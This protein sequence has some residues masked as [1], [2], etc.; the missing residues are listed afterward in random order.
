MALDDM[1]VLLGE[2]EA[3]GILHMAAVDDIGERGDALA[4]IVLQPHRAHHL[5]IDRGDLLARPQIRD[6]LGAVLFSDTEGDAAAG[7]AAV[8]PE[9]QARLLRRAAMDE[10]IDAER[11]VLADQPRRDALLEVEARSPHQRAVAEHP[12]V[13]RGCRDGGEGDFGHFGHGYQN[14]APKRSEFSAF[15]R[16]LASLT[17]AKIWGQRVAACPI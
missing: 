16:G 15:R 14:R 1:A 11:P 3:A 10:G 13:A 8:E 4:R 7:A 12:E 17:F 6:D 2:R 9:H 5:A